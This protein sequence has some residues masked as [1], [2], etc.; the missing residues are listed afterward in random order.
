MM[1]VPLIFY[2][3]GGL[4]RSA[5][6]IA[7]HAPIATPPHARSSAPTAQPPTK[8]FS[9]PPPARFSASRLI[10]AFAPDSTWARGLAWSLYGFT[11]VFAYTGRDS[12]LAVAVR[13]A[14]CFI[15]RCPESFVPPWDF[16]VPAR[17]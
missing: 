4:R 10:R 3:G 12:D 6:S 17:P 7:W 1:N 14:D 15:A 2:A 11:T 13:N 9:I 5:S 16:D 8:E